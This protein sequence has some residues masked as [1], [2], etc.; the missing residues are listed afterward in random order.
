MAERWSRPLFMALL[1]LSFASLHAARSP[2][3]VLLLQSFDEAPLTFGAVADALR[4]ELGRRMG[5]TI[6][7]VQVSLQPTGFRSIPESSTVAY[8]R[9]TFSHND[10]V[11]LIVTT[12]A[13]AALFVQRHR[14]ELFRDTPALHTMVDQRFL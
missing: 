1:L 13:P 5:E 8:L 14:R 7:F 12:G 3:R 6:N 4:T 9:S 11:D 2:V 10:R